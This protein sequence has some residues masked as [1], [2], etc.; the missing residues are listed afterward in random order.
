[1]QGRTPVNHA[2]KVVKTLSTPSDNPLK[3]ENSP[4]KGAMAHG[5]WGDQTTF[6]QRSELC[7]PTDVP[8]GETNSDV[9]TGYMTNN[10][11]DKN[12]TILDNAGYVLSAKS[13]L[14]LKGGSGGEDCTKAGGSAYTTPMYQN[15]TAA[16]LI[17]RK[18]LG[19]D[20]NSPGSHCPHATD[21]EK[22]SDEVSDYIKDT[23]LILEDMLKESKIG[24]RWIDTITHQLD[25]ILISNNRLCRASFKVIDK[26]EEQRDVLRSLQGHIND[27]HCDLGAQREK[28]NQCLLEKEN[29]IAE[30]AALRT[31][32]ISAPEKLDIPDNPLSPPLQFVN[33][34]DDCLM[35]VSPSGAS[36]ATAAAKPRVP[37]SNKKTRVIRD[38]FPVL[39][40]PIAPTSS[41]KERLGTKKPA[42]NIAK[43]KVLATNKAR[44]RSARLGPRFD[45]TTGDEGWKDL[46]KS[47][48]QKL[49]NPKIRTIKKNI[50]G[51]VLFPEDDNT[52]AALRRT[53][54]LV[55]R[56]L[57]L[58]R[59]IIKF[60]DRY[61]DKDKI[62]WALS[63]N[64]SL[65]INEQKL[66]RIKPLF[67]LG[68][69][70]GDAV[71]WVVEVAPETLPKIEGKSA[72]LGMTKCKMK[73]Y[74]LVTQCYKCQGFG[75]TAIK[76]REDQPRCK[77]CSGRHDSRNC[78]VQ[79]L[80]S[81]NCRSGSHNVASVNC[82]ARAAAIRRLTSQTDF[83]R[84][85]P[86]PEVIGAV[87]PTN[88]K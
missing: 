65:G 66:G 32:G 79:T 39:K 35:I 20:D 23:K 8:M 69:R 80:K 62:P 44:D 61:L 40:T 34:D 83:G 60:V 29:V 12:L 37:S 77:N 11:Y 52:T 14:R 41:V 25:E 7:G 53:A 84:S 64:V 2:M 51:L 87:P 74:D 28:Y 45:V 63:Q 71:H 81:P 13:T 86:T 47:I 48:E 54:N 73:F 9:P 50:G 22:Y 56:A 17:K 19:E 16:R 42:K 15:K 55:E 4:P 5:F 36:Y 18:R 24:R 26:W 1:M 76:C 3:P 10:V 49:P 85:G 30:L 75:H 67:M 31:I 6:H 88:G 38:D 70:D 57:R 82:P 78:T 27:L 59:V 33:I 58:P 21:L 72:Y 46:R 43:R 68:P